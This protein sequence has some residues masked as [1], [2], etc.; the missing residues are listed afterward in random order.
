[1]DRRLTHSR[2][3][4]LRRIAMS[5]DTALFV[6]VEGKVSDSV[7]VDALCQASPSICSAGYEVRIISQVESATG[8]FAGGKGALLSFFE[9][10]RAAGKLVQHNRGGQRAVAFVVDRDGQH[11]T[12]GKKR[13]KHLTY[14]RLADA[15]AHFFANADEPRALALAGSLDHASARLLSSSLG[16]WRRELADA[17]REWIE[18]CY[19]AD[20]VNASCWVG[21]GHD[22]SLVHR[23]TVA[24]K[25]DATKCAEA[26]SAVSTTSPLPAPD[27]ATKRAQILAKIDETYNRGR[28]ATLLKGKWLPARVTELVSLH[29]GGTRSTPDG[30][31]EE[32]FKA[33]VTRCYA[34]YLDVSSPD[35]V[36]MRS[37]L[38]ALL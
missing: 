23:G 20:A 38:E 6:F 22:R 33:S 5:H 10:C 17:W 12:G 26:H 1:M 29:F 35:M 4:L 36:A 37:R 28:Q 24:A 3:G 18:L 13:S 25:L 7:L 31:H 30:W 27:F 19:V 2:A 15:E 8:A 21:F 9:Y 14:T 34:A 16:D 32:G 11:I